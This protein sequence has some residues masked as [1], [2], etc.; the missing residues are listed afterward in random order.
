[1]IYVDT[2]VVVALLT[3]EPVTD[4]VTAWFEGIDEP[5]V[6]ADWCAVEFASAISIK[7]RS[8]QLKPKY[9]KAIH[10]SFE[11]LCAG[12]LRLLPVSREAYRRAADL[13]RSPADSLRAGDALHLAVAI[14]GRVQALAGLDRTMNAAAQRLGLRLAVGGDATSEGR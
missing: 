6:S 14:E 13:S 5:L 8:G 11:E 7:Q 3:R 2:S 9:A 10:D 4:A 12:G 1:M